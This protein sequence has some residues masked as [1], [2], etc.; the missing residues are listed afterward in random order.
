VGG[1]EVASARARGAIACARG[2]SGREWE[3]ETVRVR[4]HG[5]A[6]LGLVGR[7]LGPYSARS[8]STCSARGVILHCCSV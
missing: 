4:G 3:S 7:T 5:N 2:V 8:F 6:H 1:G